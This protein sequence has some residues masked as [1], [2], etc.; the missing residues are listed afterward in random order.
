MNSHA[1]S[2]AISCTNLYRLSHAYTLFV[3]VASQHG[4][5]KKWLVRIVVRLL[6]LLERTLNFRISF[7]YILKKT[8]L[9][10]VPNRNWIEWIKKTLLKKK[11]LSGNNL[12][13]NYPT[14]TRILD[15]YFQD[16]FNH[17]K[18]Y[19]TSSSIFNKDLTNKLHDHFIRY[20]ILTEIHLE[21]AY[22]P[23]RQ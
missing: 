7:K 4:Q 5:R 10:N 11:R 19:L 8:R 14:S 3:E 22:Q 20:L 15:Q 17:I 13:W 21:A 16:Y 9:R 6:T 18:V 12:R 23:Q 1:Q 2:V